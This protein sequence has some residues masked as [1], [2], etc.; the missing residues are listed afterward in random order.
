MGRYDNRLKRTYKNRSRKLPQA[1]L[2]PVNAPNRPAKRKQWSGEQMT[3]AME[4]VTDRT[5]VSINQ[6]AREYGVPASTL[7]DRLSCRVVH[8]T[9][10][11][12]VSYLNAD[13]EAD[14]AV[15]IE[16]AIE[17]GILHSSLVSDGWW[18]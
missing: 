3:A 5:A 6:A 12:P 13:E 7:K 9:K 2:S 17:R 4:A 1:P 8:G 15:Y 10:P 16:V 14:L 11:G 18:K